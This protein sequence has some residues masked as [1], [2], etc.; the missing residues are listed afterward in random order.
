M[1]TLPERGVSIEAFGSVSSRN[2]VGETAMS[3]E[4]GVDVLH[5]PPN[6]PGTG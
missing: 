6:R 2:V 3:A 1:A 5:G 4:N